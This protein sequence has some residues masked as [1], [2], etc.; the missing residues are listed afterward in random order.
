MCLY[1]TKSHEVWL[2]PVGGTPQNSQD[3]DFSDRVQQS[4]LFLINFEGMDNDNIVL[5]QRI[6]CSIHSDFS[7]ANF[8]FMNSHFTWNWFGYILRQLVFV[9]LHCYRKWM[10]IYNNNRISKKLEQETKLRILVLLLMAT[11]MILTSFS[12]M[13]YHLLTAK[14]ESIKFSNDIGVM[15]NFMSRD[16]LNHLNND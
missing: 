10:F 9:Y 2:N 12:K 15:A 6:W 4:V 16:R 5:N 14:T 1:L 11:S 13:I 3:F 8:E 7:V